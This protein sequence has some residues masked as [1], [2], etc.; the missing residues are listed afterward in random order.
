[1]E[2]MEK[3]VSGRGISVSK[4]M[5][6]RVQVCEREGGQGQMLEFQALSEGS[7]K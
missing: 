5:E 2:K 1:M 3:R 6:H 7:G 4:G